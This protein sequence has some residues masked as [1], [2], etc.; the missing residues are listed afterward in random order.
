MV[1]LFDP[2]Q[3][4]IENIVVVQRSIFSS[5]AS[6]RGSRNGTF[7]SP[8]QLVLGRNDRS[9]QQQRALRGRSQESA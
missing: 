4:E 8:R 2:V 7:C 5:L 6:G 9:L 3:C 1:C